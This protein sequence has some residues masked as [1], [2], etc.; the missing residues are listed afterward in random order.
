MAELEFKCG[1]P[2]PSITLGSS[3]SLERKQIRIDRKGPH[4][5]I[6]PYGME[7]STWA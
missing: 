3:G 2:Y 6:I 7:E 1:L 5:A 4:L